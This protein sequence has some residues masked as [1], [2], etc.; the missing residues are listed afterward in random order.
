MVCPNIWVAV[1]FVGG[2]ALSVYSNTRC[3]PVSETYKFAD[4]SSATL[5]GK[6]SE[7]ADALP[8][9]PVVKEPPCPHTS[10]GVVSPLPAI[11]V[12][13]RGVL[14]SRTRLLLKSAS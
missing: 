2:L 7:V 14:N 4:A 6:Q 1:W 8:Q 10:S 3:A 13:V 5:S 9:V 11:I 12:T